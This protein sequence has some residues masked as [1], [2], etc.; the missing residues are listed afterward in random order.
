MAPRRPVRALRPSSA[1]PRRIALISRV[2]HRTRTQQIP[3][4]RR[5]AQTLRASARP[6]AGCFS[7]GAHA[8]S[9]GGAHARWRS[10]VLNLS[11]QSHTARS[12]PFVP[13]PP[14]PRPTPGRGTR[15]R[16][17][18]APGT[19]QTYAAPERPENAEKRRRH[20]EERK[21]LKEAFIVRMISSC[22]VQSYMRKRTGTWFDRGTGPVR[23]IWW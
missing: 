2:H 6:T 20:L 19:A 14:H 15:R 8:R 16:A 18:A 12:S 3:R 21:R 1:R 9:C 5:R 10:P 13:S 17:G 23:S 4:R 11:A 22:K 7:L